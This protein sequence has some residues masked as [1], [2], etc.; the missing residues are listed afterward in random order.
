MSIVASKG[1]F[2]WLLKSSNKSFFV[3][4]SGLTG[5]SDAVEKACLS[6]ADGQ[7]L[8]S[9]LESE[10]LAFMG[11]NVLWSCNSIGFSCW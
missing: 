10:S 5:E 9:L 1:C 3:Q 4:Q 6:K 11:T 7:N 8:E 2:K